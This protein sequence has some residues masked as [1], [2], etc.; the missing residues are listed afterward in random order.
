MTQNAQ[1]ET[2]DSAKLKELDGFIGR[3]P[4]KKNALIQTLHAAQDIFGYLPQY[5]QSHI[6]KELQVPA[7][8]VFGVVTFYSFLKTEPSGKVPVSV[9]LGTACFVRGAEEIL[10]EFKKELKIENGGMTEDGLFSLDS[11]R[12][13]GA[14]GLA[15]VVMVGGQVFGRVERD[16]VKEIIDDFMA[17]EGLDND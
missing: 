17:K 9:C 13:V 11:I 15:P 16:H 1:V 6:A 4:T 3:L 2:I 8:R 14:C 12:C 5:V 7:S 10:D